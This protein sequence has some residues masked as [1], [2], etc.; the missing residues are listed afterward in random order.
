[1][2]RKLHE[3]RLVDLLR[4][5]QPEWIEQYPKLVAREWKAQGKNSEYGIGD[6]VFANREKTRYLVVEL[7]SL[8]QGSGSLARLYRS[9]ARKKC[10][11]QAQKYGRIWAGMHPDCEVTA[12]AF[13][14]PEEPIFYGPF[15]SVAEEGAT[16]T[17]RLT[18]C[19]NILRKERN[20]RFSFRMISTLLVAGSIA[21]SLLA[22][23]NKLLE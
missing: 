5:K 3:S 20:E 15:N 18:S 9:R 12:C 17:S 1:M 8:R 23:L 16:T 11:D 2:K 4:R 21:I 14:Y 19:K 13:A 22:D 7:K 6:L 10:K